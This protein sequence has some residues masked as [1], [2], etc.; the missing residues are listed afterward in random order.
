MNSVPRSAISIE[1]GEITIDAELVAYK[2]GV[3]TALLQAGMPKGVVSSVAETGIDEDVGRTRL[4][5]RYR[6]RTWRVVVES[7]G[8]LVESMEPAPNALPASTGRLGPSDLARR[9]P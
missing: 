4:T 3:S 9:G 6:S 8:S 1:D 7:D 5:F 2:L